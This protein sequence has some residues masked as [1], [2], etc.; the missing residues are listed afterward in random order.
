MFE[1]DPVITWVDQNGQPNAEDYYLSAYVQVCI[2]AQ[3]SDIRLYIT[4]VL[5]IHTCSYV[6]LSYCCIK[7]ECCVCFCQCRDGRG[8]CPDTRT[9]AFNC[10]NDVRN[11]SGSIRDGVQCVTYTRSF[12]GSQ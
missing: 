12:A 3:Y 8:A 9:S 5:I 2:E 11:V 6:K 7:Y 4:Q 1:A 10:T